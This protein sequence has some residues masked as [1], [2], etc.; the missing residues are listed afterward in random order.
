MLCNCHHAMSAKSQ[1]FQMYSLYMVD[2][3]MCPLSKPLVE[4]CIDLLSFHTSTLDVSVFC[5]S[6]SIA[7]V[8]AARQSFSGSVEEPRHGD[9]T[10]QLG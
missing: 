6:C 10:K 9:F 7:N 2:T 4:G 8:G 5:C 1:V 3:A